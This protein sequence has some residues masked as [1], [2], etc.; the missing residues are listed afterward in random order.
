MSCIYKELLI[1]NHKQIMRKNRLQT[2]TWLV[3]RRPRT[4]RHADGV[5]GKDYIKKKENRYKSTFS[6][7][8]DAKW[9]RTSNNF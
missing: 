3:H 6:D 2:L 7:L 9:H 1:L 5:Y 8:Y 4:P